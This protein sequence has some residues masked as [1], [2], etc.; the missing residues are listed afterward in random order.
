MATMRDVAALAGVSAKTV[1]RVFN[2]EPNVLPETRVAVEKAMAELNYV[3]NSLATTFR[4]GRS[5]VIGVAVPDISDPFFASIARSI[6]DVAR[7]NKMSTLVASLTETN[8]NEQSIIESLLGFQ[9]S[10]LVICPVGKNHQWLEKWKQQVPI[11]FVDRVPDGANFDAF[12][13]D[14]E[15]NGYLAT[16]HLIAKGHRRIAYLGDRL[17][18]ITEALRVE[19]WKRALREIGVDPEPDLLV[20][21]DST[22]EQTRAAI[23]RLMAL[24]EP[25]TAI[26]SG[27]PRCTMALAHVDCFGTFALISLGDFPLSEALKPTISV[28][29]QNPGELGRLA[30]ERIIYRLDKDNQP[31]SVRTVLDVKLIERESCSISA[32]R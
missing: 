22:V 12:I 25:P 17:E 30:A 18:L 2:G 31:A 29:D 11:V 16:K 19:G 13:E 1:S 28:I 27:N 21:A 26:F 20:S 15:H 3:P 23:D 24:P 10:G 6:D 32:P 5:S 9:L 8:E 7:Q 4:A 14:D